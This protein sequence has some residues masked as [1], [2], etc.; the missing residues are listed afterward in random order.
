MLSFKS[1][2]FQFGKT[3]IFEDISLNFEKGKTYG[4]IGANGVGK[5]TLFRSIS[6]LYHLSNGRIIL[7]DL[8][9]HSTDVSF[10]PT[11]PFFYP[12]MKGMEYLQ[13]I[14]KSTDQLQDCIQLAELL[15]IPL[16]NL[17]DTYS[18]GMKKKLA[19]IARYTQNNLV[20]IYD[21]PFNGVDLESNEVLLKLLQKDKGNKITLISSHI[22]SMLY[23]LCDEI[24]HIEKEF[25]ISAYSPSQYDELKA[26]IRGAI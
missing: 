11:D 12:Y 22:L 20:S 6:G 8:P 4:I 16:D 24:L 15:N 21:E 17:V 10:L 23:E 18:T 26:K 9:I 25:L 1:I 13:I 7:N 19:F 2:S 14:Q 5:T 3:S